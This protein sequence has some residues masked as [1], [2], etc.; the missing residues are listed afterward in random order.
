[1]TAT[2][3]PLGADLAVDGPVGTARTRPLGDRRWFQRLVVWGGLTIAYEI[4]ARIVGSY[5]LPTVG[6]IA[7]ATVD[8]VT[9]GTIVTLARSLSQLL[10]G[11]LIATA[12]G[13][14]LGLLLGASRWADVALG[15]YVRA[16]FATSLIALLPL[17]I[18]LA[19]IGFTFRVTV[20][21]LL[22]VFFIIL[23]TSAGVR[24]VDPALVWTARSF[25]AGPT[26]IFAKVIFPAS[27][28]F[29]VAGLRIGLANAFGAMIVAEL[30]VSRDTG[31]LLTHLAL[32]RDLPPFFSLL[33]IVTL[34]ATLS[35]AGLKA[36]ERRFAVGV[37]EAR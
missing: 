12:V 36:L 25:M 31:E 19:G 22:S 26:Q 23:N 21:C 3:T 5:F 15:M 1:V 6:D 18:I 16:L 8:I 34:I 20:V 29:I 24:N 33:F 27:L 35:A 32:N 17:L 14:P 37:P 11:F 30:W 4:V 2:P 28:P 7:I 10:V 9:D 13:V